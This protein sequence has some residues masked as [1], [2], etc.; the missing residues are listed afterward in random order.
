MTLL[1]LLDKMPC[2]IDAEIYENNERMFV[3]VGTVDCAKKTLSQDILSRKVQRYE[4]DMPGYRL[5]VD[6]AD[7][8]ELV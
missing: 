2:D 6:L 5:T 4:R 1:D 8:I 7:S 3:F